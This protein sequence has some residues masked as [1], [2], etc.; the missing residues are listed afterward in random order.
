MNSLSVGTIYASSIVGFTPGGGSVGGGLVSTANLAN[1]VST[2]LLNTAFG[3]TLTSLGN[4]FTTDHL[5]TSLF[6][7][8]STINISA[9][10]SIYIDT[11]NNIDLHA[12]GSINI[13][14]SGGLSLNNQ[15]AIAIVS[16]LTLFY[17]PSQLD[18]A[19]VYLSSILFAN[20]NFST[21]Q[22]TTDPTLTNLYWNGSQLNDQGGGGG[23]ISQ[24]NLTSTV[25]G[26]GTVGYIST[27]GAN[28][29]FSTIITSTLQTAHIQNTSEYLFMDAP[30]TIFGTPDFTSFYP[31]GVSS[32][33]FGG[34]AQITQDATYN[35]FVD[36]PITIFG[37]PDL[38]TS[39]P[40][41]VSSISL[42][43]GQITTDSTYTNLYWNDSQINSQYGFVTLASGRSVA[44]YDANITASTIIL[45]TPYGDIGYGNTFWVTL[46]T[47]TL[48]WLVNIASAL[49]G[50][51]DFSYHILKY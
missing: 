13:S 7:S 40:I 50:P 9:N 3:S 30:I 8:F 6:T 44:T 12:G 33:G 24:A 18:L 10:N 29:L 25:I 22:I 28:G 37:T 49:A 45:V 43:G 20:N 1:L 42:G 11:F 46:D 27:P 31:I 14:S 26:L 19:P 35:L 36:S 15:N 4:E 39:Y 38:S 41:V 17:A 51:V 5:I 34:G 16:P 47:G 23:G 2:S 21:S 48:E 32:I